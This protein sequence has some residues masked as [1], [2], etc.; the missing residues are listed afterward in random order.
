KRILLDRLPTVL[1]GYGKSLQA[2]DAVVVVVDLDDRHCVSFKQE[3]LEIQKRC[4]PMPEVLFRLAIEE[5]EAW[6][7]GDR[8]AIVK[9]F[10]RAKLNTLHSYGQDSIGGTWERLADALF[11]GGSPALKA[12]GYPR[13]G[14]EKCKWASLIGR[15]LDVEANLS[16]SLRVFRSGL[17]KLTAAGK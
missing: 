13:I 9:A 1:A 16:P 11:P 8:N 15:H 3:L 4:N 12:L 14:M 6:L 10:P 17:L 7:L 2:G 5:I